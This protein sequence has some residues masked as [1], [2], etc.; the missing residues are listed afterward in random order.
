M[1]YDPKYGARPVAR[2]V[3][4][5]IQEKL[6][7]AILFGELRKGGSARVGVRRGEIALSFHPEDG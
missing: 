1:G 3:Q 4:A 5:E 2:L 7:D 6:V